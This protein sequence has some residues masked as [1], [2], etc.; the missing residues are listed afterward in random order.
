M[1]EDKLLVARAKQGCRDAL[2]SIYKKYS[3]HLFILAIALC[4]NVDEA[5][6]AVCEV[7]V[8]FAEKLYDFKLTGS[9]KAYLSTCVANRIRNRIRQS[10]RKTTAL[11]ESCAITSDCDGPCD[12]IILNEQLEQLSSALASLP[13]EQREVIPLR[14]YRKLGF[15]AIAGELGI[16]ANTARGRYRYGMKKL[17]SVF[18]HEV[19]K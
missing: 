10:S 18:S 1:T 15:Y 2:G 17:Q 12:K 6:D 9:L 13:Y 11:S 4:H 3:N 5:E 8:S 16:S 14:I 19:E 7:F